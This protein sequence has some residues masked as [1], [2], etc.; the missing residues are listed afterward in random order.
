MSSD[1]SGMGIWVTSPAK[2]L[3]PAE[4][5]AEDRGNLEYIVVEGDGKCLLFFKIIPIY[6]FHLRK[7]KKSLKPRRSTTQMCI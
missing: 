3:R 7:K 5:V 2:I 1:F 4:V 6:K